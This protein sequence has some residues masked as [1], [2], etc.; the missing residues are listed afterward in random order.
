MATLPTLSPEVQPVMTPNEEREL[1]IVVKEHERPPYFH[2]EEG[3]GNRLNRA[4]RLVTEGRITPNS[5]GSYTV[6][7][8]AGR[9]YRCAESCSCP[10]SQRAKSK[11][12]YHLVAVALYVEWQRRLQPLLLPPPLTVDQRLAHGMARDST[13]FAASHTPQEDIMSEQA[14]TEGEALHVTTAILEPPRGMTALALPRRSIQAIVADLS[15][16]LPAACVAQKTQGGQV[17]PFLHW[18]TVARVLDAY[19]P[20]WYGQVTR[21]DQVGNTCVITYR[22]T[23]PCLEGEVYREATGQEEEEVKGYGD[24]SSNAEAM[25]LKRAAAKFGLGAWLYDKDETARALKKHLNDEKVFVFELLKAEL[26]R[27]G[28]EHQPTLDWLKGQ[29]GAQRNDEIP[30]G[31][32][33]AL[34]THLTCTEAQR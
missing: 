15:R 34:L 19:A 31:A 2:A 28:L 5:D 21:L 10:N 18:Q 1:W 13:A 23:I 25:A 29:T 22:L 9:T 30:V 33:R 16:P 27:I 7:G 24:P 11:W 17:I 32:V 3:I 26:T 14:Y 6:E 20:G 12:C 4:A 8:S